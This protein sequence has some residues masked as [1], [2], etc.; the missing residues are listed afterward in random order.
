MPAMKYALMAILALAALGGMGGVL[1]WFFK[2][3]GRIETERWGRKV[4]LT[5]FDVKG[6]L[7]RLFR[8]KPAT[9]PRA[10]R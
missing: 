8:K 9:P 4:G 3:L 6:K 1:V 7:A 10:Q 2:R 5:T